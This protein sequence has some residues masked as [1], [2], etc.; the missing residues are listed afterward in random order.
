MPVTAINYYF[1][2]SFYVY[3]LDIHKKS[4]SSARLIK[5][6][7]GERKEGKKKKKK[8]QFSFFT[9]ISPSAVYFGI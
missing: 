4:V 5:K 2:S 9:L 8:F 1:F 3:L 6:R 7:E